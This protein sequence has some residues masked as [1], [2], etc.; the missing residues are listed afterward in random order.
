MNSMNTNVRPRSRAS[1]KRARVVLW[2]MIAASLAAL[3][4][5]V[6]GTVRFENPLPGG[7]F[8]YDGWLIILFALAALTGCGLGLCYAVRFVSKG[9]TS[10][11]PVRTGG[12]EPGARSIGRRA[13]QLLVVLAAMVGGALIF[14]VGA[15]YVMWL[16][17][18]VG[19]YVLPYVL[20]LLMEFGCF[21]YGKRWASR[22]VAAE[23]SQGGEAE[24]QTDETKRIEDLRGVRRFG[25][26][27]W[28]TYRAEVIGIVAGVAYLI[29]GVL[30]VVDGFDLRGSER[31][32]IDGREK[33]GR[34]QE[35]PEKID[36]L[37]AGLPSE[38]DSRSASAQ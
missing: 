2:V 9:T 10:D 5:M 3:V 6:E 1:L 21:W 4:A 7:V 33:S 35:L 14:Y 12:A 28:L 16:I 36:S 15:Y 11:E 17:L 27:L 34:I 30:F 38:V 37:R 31:L 8:R 18:E 20:L 32:Q 19:A 22:P 26:R 13:K 23:R 25:A 24:A 29:A